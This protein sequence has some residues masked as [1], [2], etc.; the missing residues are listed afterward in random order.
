[1]ETMTEDERKALEEQEKNKKDP[2]VQELVDQINKLKLETVS[3]EE[4]EQILKTNSTLVKEIANNRPAPQVTPETN[5]REAK[6][7][8]IEGRYAKRRIVTGKQV[9]YLQFLLLMYY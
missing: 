9:Y 3:K 5:T 6:V 2:T 4:Y 1:M 7:K 8:V